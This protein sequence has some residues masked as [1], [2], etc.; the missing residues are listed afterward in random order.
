MEAK[1][2][3]MENPFVDTLFSLEWIASAMDAARRHTEERR[4]ARAANDDRYEPTSL[5]EETE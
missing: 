2:D 5:D 4:R 1:D 3:G